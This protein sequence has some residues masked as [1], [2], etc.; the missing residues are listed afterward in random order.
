MNFFKAIRLGAAGLFLSFG[1]SSAVDLQIDDI[2]TQPGRVEVRFFQHPGFY[3]IL[4]RGEEPANIRVATDLVRALTWPDFLVDT[5]ATNAALFY[6]VEK[7]LMAAQRDT[8]GDGICDAFELLYRQ[9]GAA[10]NPNDANEDHNGNGVPDRTDALRESYREGAVRGRP[11]LAAGTQHSLA[12]RQDGTLWGWGDNLFGELGSDLF[13]ETNVPVQI[14]ADTN[15]L[16]VSAAG[17]A[18]Y[19]LKRDG[20]LWFWGAGLTGNVFTPTQI[21]TNQNWIGLPTGRP[22]NNPT[23]LQADGSRWQ[24]VGSF[25]NAQRVETNQWLAVADDNSSGHW[26]V[27]TDGTLWKNNVLADGGTNWTSIS[28]GYVHALALQTDGSLWAWAHTG[29]P[30][31]EGQ[32]GLENSSP[33]TP[34]R[35]GVETWSSVAAGG[36]HSVGI[37]ADGS[38]WWW[39][40]NNGYAPQG[41]GLRSTNAPAR[42][43]TNTGWLAVFAADEH[44]LALHKDGTVWTFGFNSIGRVGNGTVAL[45][46]EPTRVGT[47]ADW[48]AAAIGNLYSLGVKSNG[49]LWAWG[50]NPFGVLGVGDFNYSATPRQVPGSNWL[51]VSGGG[52]HSVGLKTDGTLWVWGKHLYGVNSG[53]EVWT[54][55]PTQ[56]GVDTDWVKISAGW[57]HS[58]AM[59]A[60]RSL[61]AWGRNVRGELGNGETFGT[62][63]FPVAVAG[64]GVWTNF[65]AGY[66]ASLGVRGTVLYQ[67]GG[68]VG[69][70][71]FP[72]YNS[73]QQVGGTFNWLQVANAKSHIIS[74]HALALKQNGTLWTWG[75]NSR[76][77]LGTNDTSGQPV[78][79]GTETNWIHIAA[80]ELFSAARRVDGT[81]WMT[82]NNGL[83]QLGLGTRTDTNL[84]TRL[85]NGTNWASIATGFT[86]TLGRQSDGTLWAW[87]DNSQGQCAQPAV[88][89][90]Q[91]VGGTNWGRAQ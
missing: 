28:L 66:Y 86:H 54:N 79:V 55:S 61:W 24:F 62:Q 82:G 6:R 40:V 3:Y 88:F 85:G 46:K 31:V 77:Q 90:P 51:A 36:Y 4:W 18:S 57:Q 60:N 59:K 50:A 91:P 52:D 67:W 75:A 34:T 63:N 69:S 22:Q 65:S 58:L 25:T 35:I 84:F 30:A 53:N 70:G 76:G 29:T 74:S 48:S 78:Q 14:G 42:F 44:T 80:G 7:V 87:G 89:E 27:R 2:Q 11:V 13:T 5:N 8:D 37:K 33:S 1:A 10:L 9:P 56:L 68:A 21:G 41:N 38:L 12:I 73:P 26:S 16:A 32:L 23:A 71:G 17:F 43:G 45:L 72:N 47:D 83:G 49:T 20:T 64:G 39:G 15:W 19:G 81:V